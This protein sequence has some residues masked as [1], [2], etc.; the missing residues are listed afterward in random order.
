MKTA[1][2]L[3]VTT[4]S[5]LHDRDGDDGQRRRRRQNGGGGSRTLVW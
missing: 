1:M 5:A 3:D 4:A 2:K